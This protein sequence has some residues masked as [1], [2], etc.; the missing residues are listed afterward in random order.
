[1]LLV[2][3]SPAGAQQEAIPAPPPSSLEVEGRQAEEIWIVTKSG[4]FR[5][6]AEIADDPQERSRGL[7]F[8]K[9][10]PPKHGMLFDFGEVRPV[11]MWM[12]NTPLSLDMVFLDETGTVTSIAERTTPFSDAIIDSGGPIS[13]VLE[14]NAGIVRLIGLQPGDRVEHA[15]FEQ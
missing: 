10:M 15:S 1:M 13:H 8:R 6:T 7:M 9:S 12:R 11:H 14:L 3:G 5:F 2:A 4:R